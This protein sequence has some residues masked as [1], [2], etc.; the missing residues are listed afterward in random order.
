MT[1]HLRLGVLS[2]VVLLGAARLDAQTAN[3]GAR[4]DRQI[5][6]EPGTFWSPDGKCA[7]S[8][9]RNPLGGHLTMSTDRA[10]KRDVVDVSGVAWLTNRILV[11]TVSPIYGKPG[12]FTLTCPS[13]RITRIVAPR[14]KTKAYPDGADYF[15]LVRV[16]TSQKVPLVYFYY[17]P[18][19][20]RVDFNEFRTVHYLF[21]VRTDGIDFRKAE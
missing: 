13:M 6:Q 7:V 4:D 20:D 3:P 21:Q 8:L 11:Y 15:E 5:I 18:D 2:F 16:S 10:T 1:G 19:A 17:A 9:S 14:T 12:V